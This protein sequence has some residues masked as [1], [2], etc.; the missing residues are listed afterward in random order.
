MIPGN[1][2]ALGW[3]TSKSISEIPHLGIRQNTTWCHIYI[4][5]DQIRLPGFKRVE[6]K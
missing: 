1:D 4:A 5:I 2:H 3:T 6:M